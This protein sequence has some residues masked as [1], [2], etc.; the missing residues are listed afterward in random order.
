MQLK[1]SYK[2]I[3]GIAYPIMISSVAQNIINLTDTIFLGRVGQT[4]LAAIGL[5][6]I[7]F[8]S[9]VMIGLGFSKGAQIIIARRAGEKNF[10]GIAQIFWN[11][12]YFQ[13]SAA[14]IIFLLL[15][16][17]GVY[18][19]SL[20]VNSASILN[21][22]STYLDYRNFSLFFS[23]SGFA[24][25]SFYTGIGKTKIIIYST[26]ILALLNIGLNY[27]FVFGKLGIQPMGIAGAGLASSIAE[28]G[29]Y[30][31]LLFFTFLSSIQKQF[32]LFKNHYLNISLIKKMVKL[33]MP[34]VTQFMFGIGSWFL[35]FSCIEKLGEQELAV[36]NIIKTL[37]L[38]FIVP[39]TGL[40]S[41][42]QTV[43]SNLLGQSG[44]N[45]VLSTS[46]KIIWLSIICTAVFCALIFFFP[47]S[48]LSLITNDASLISASKPLLYLLTSILML[49]A[50]SSA[51]YYTVIG[52]G[53]I[54]V[55]LKIQIAAVI[56]YLSFTYFI[57]FIA[58]GNLLM[59]WSAEFV[60]WLIIFIWSVWYIRSNKWKQLKF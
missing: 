52:V 27:V 6:G 53:A 50:I 55:S 54:G 9:F 19:L 12:F 23:F 15:H 48:L 60:Y 32:E 44:Q 5:V 26:V 43:I 14:I 46:I 20:F 49:Y 42:G 33:S 7:F 38:F 57:V 11:V 35:F 3:W 8:Y 13:L 10:T 31:F 36:S 16:F 4:E 56:G 18:I 24:L 30:L 37:Y 34:I 41:A 17:Y 39:T 29:A 21:A 58:K 1:P 25:I 47:E 2:N 22:S 51:T 28:G 40:G 45:M 59:A